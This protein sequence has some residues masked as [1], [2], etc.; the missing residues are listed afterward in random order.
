MDA[1]FMPIKY[2]F[3]YLYSSL[4]PEVSI[5]EIIVYILAINLSSYEYRIC[6]IFSCSERERL[7]KS[8]YK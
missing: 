7:D 8:Q 5:Y 3:L 4:T 6:S 1:F 2:N